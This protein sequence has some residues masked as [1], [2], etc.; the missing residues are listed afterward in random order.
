MAGWVF[1]PR[2][3]DGG[4]TALPLHTSRAP[5]GEK[6]GGAPGTTVIRLLQRR[7][8]QISGTNNRT[9]QWLGRCG[10]YIGDLRIP[11]N[12]SVTRVF[13]RQVM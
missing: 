5:E 1:R 6:I 3:K 2:P 9:G 8:K 4:R 10:K 12:I 13:H 11:G 7:V